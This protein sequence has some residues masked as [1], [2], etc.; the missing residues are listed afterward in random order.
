LYE[1]VE[2]A[3]RAVIQSSLFIMLM[4]VNIEKKKLMTRT[5][6]REIKENGEIM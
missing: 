6:G 5:L 3:Y 4:Y 1:R 2:S